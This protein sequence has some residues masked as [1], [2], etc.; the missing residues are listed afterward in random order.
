M[1]GRFLKDL[2]KPAILAVARPVSKKNLAELIHAFGRSERLRTTANLVLI[3]GNRDTITGSDE[4]DANLREML[5]LIDRYDLYGSV[6]YPKSHHVHQMAGIYHYAATTG[7]VFVNPALNEPF[8]LTLLE[9]A[10]VGL[11]V[12]ATN[13][14]GP[15][16]IIGRLRCGTLVTPDDRPGLTTAIEA[17][18]TDRHAWA[19]ANRNGAERIALYDWDAHVDRYLGLA[20]GVLAPSRPRQRRPSR[21]LA[22]DIDGTLVGCATSLHRFAAWQSRQDDMLYGVATGRS[23][24]AALD[25]L[26]AE[27]AP[28]PPL[29]IV[30]VGS[31]I[32]W[33]RPGSPRYERDTHWDRTIADGWDRATVD[34][35][36]AG[37][38]GFERQP[39]MEQRRHKLSYFV[40]EGDA[41]ERVAA[42]R[43]A[44]HGQAERPHGL[45]MP[46]GAR[47]RHSELVGDMRIVGAQRM[48]GQCPL[49]RPFLILL[50]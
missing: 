25:V 7:G 45:R 50:H 8:G 15:N 6:A 5:E 18:L 4:I 44:R 10:S 37:M 33:Q 1:L 31:E 21:L 23:L 35:L 11:P 47:Q 41:D 19:A 29:M 24:H 36:T 12:V 38:G 20:R 14:G 40:D 34:R 46:P 27:G 16:D 2:T 26:E 13:R 49:P 39:A 48:R 30:N 28:L 43:H 42:L 9:A 22:T 17:L 32:Y 3:A